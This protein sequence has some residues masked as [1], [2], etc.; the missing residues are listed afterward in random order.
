MFDGFLIP[1]ESV[2]QGCADEVDDKAEDPIGV[3]MRSAETST[4]STHQ[5][6][7]KKLRN[8]R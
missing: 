3:S 4:Q 7:K 6:I 1:D 8:C 5:T 2:R